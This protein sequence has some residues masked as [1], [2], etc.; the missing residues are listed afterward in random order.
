MDWVLAGL[1]GCFCYMDDV[2]L[3]SRN[4]TD[5]LTLVDELLRRLSE[6]G[7]SIHLEKCIFGV[8][9]LEFLGWNVSPTGISPLPKMVEAIAAFPA[10]RTPKGP[11]RV[12][13]ST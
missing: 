7:L 1:D 2:L 12:P 9:K 3:H 11:L 4:E 13:G 5:H 10:P 8:E 6:A